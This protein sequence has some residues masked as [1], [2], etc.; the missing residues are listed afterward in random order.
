MASFDIVSEVDGQKLD[1]AINSARKEILSRYDFKGSES[2][3]D[4]D[5]KINKIHVVTEDNMKLDAIEGIIFQKLQKQGLDSNCLDV[6]KEEY[7]AGNKLKKD[8]DVKSGIEKE[9]AKKIVKSI[10]E[11]KLK[12]DSSIMDEK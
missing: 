10:K 3:I 12:V 5:K 6:G 9:T 8:I 7:A 11:L 2:S 4:L 1:N